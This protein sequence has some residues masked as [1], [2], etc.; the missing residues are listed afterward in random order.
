[1]WGMSDR[2]VP[3]I[4]QLLREHGLQVTAQ[5]V[6]VLERVVAAYVARMDD[7]AATISR[8]MGAPGWLSGAAPGA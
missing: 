4:E 8:E 1:M 7:L 2:D 6:A 5:R 3:S